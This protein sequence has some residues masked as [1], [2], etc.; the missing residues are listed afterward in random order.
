MKN[1]ITKAMLM[2]FA[3]GI[4][5]AFSSCEK[6]EN[7]TADNGSYD[8]GVVLDMNNSVDRIKNLPDDVRHE[9]EE[10]AMSRGIDLDHVEERLVTRPN[11]DVQRIFM[12]EEDIE[13]TPEQFRDMLTNKDSD[14]QYITNN[15]ANNNQTYTVIGYTGS[16]CALTSKMQ[17]ALQWAVNNFNRENL[18]ITLSLSYGTNYQN[19]DI[20]V[21]N[22]GAGGGGGSAGFPFSNGKPYNFVQINAGTDAFNTNVVEHVI[23]HELGHCF[24]FRHTDYFNRSISC[25]SGG[26]EGSAGV[27]ANQVPGIPGFDG[28]SIMLACFSND[29]DGE[30]SNNDIVALEFMYPN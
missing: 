20:T 13:M 21:Y 25:G 4:L 12:V 28:N 2:V 10:R 6:Q 14:R 9:I 27:G 16:C 29:E 24:G 30:F 1:L 22:N 5:V 8:S 17:T 15:L 26:N 7:L 3:M 11:G 23:C 19:K 18:G